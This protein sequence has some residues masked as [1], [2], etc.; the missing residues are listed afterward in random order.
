MDIALRKKNLQVIGFLDNESAVGKEINGFKVLGS[1]IKVT[2]YVKQDCNFIIGVGQ[3]KSPKQR[4]SLFNKILF[5]KGKLLNLFAT[6][7]IISPSARFGRGVTIME[8]AIIGPNVILGN[9]VIVNTNAVIEHDSVIED[10]CHV[11]TGAIINGTCRIGK[12]S[13]IGSGSIIKQGVT[14]GENCIIS[15][16]QG[17]KYDL[18][19]NST[20]K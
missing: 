7:A 15:M 10:F 4:I 14:V 17:I 11:S 3:I 18:L 2:E 1:D 5:H 6:S 13:F 20:F 12:G 8:G 9:G 19:S 16:H